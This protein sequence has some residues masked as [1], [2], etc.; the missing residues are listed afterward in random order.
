MD[1]E[2]TPVISVLVPT[3]NAAEYLEQC[4]DSIAAQTT[5]AIEIIVI[6]DGSTDGSGAIADSYAA[7][8]NRFTVVH[9]RNTGYGDSLNEGLR[10]AHGTWISIVEPD[11]WIEATMFED[12]LHHAEAVAGKEE[13]LDIVKGSYTRIVAHDS[14]RIDYK[15]GTLSGTTPPNQPFTIDECPTLLTAHPSIWS[16]LYR[17]SFLDEFGIRFLPVPGAGWA[18]NPFFLESMVAARKIAWLDKSVYNYREFED[19][20]VSHLK[21][22]H[23]ITDRWA[24][25]MS[26]LSRYDVEIPSVLE[27]HYVRGCAYLQMLANDFDQNDPQLVA[28]ASAMA[29]T[30][31]HG[32]VCRSALISKEYKLAYAR[33]VPAGKRASLLASWIALHLRAL[34]GHLPQVNHRAPRS[35]QPGKS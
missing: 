12:L 6:D 26:I 20:T 21:D 5:R 35:S 28:A 24:D 8:D 10:R 27:A 4:L 31:D 33:F 1:S 30:F 13:P 22:W 25:M 32:I 23:I 11:D 29:A 15:P 16:A 14:Q 2:K 7:R 18:D 34:C 19:G 17:K 3:F 9:K